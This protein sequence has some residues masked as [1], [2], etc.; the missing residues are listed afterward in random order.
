MT[1]PI[2]RNA[3]RRG[4]LAVFGLWLGA[5][6]PVGSA[7]A[8][9]APEPLVT[10]VLSLAELRNVVSE[11]GRSIRSFRAE[12]LVCAVNRDRS[13]L[14][15]QDS[16]AGLVLE[17]PALD[18]SI[19]PGDWVQVAGNECALTRCRFGLQ[20]GTAPVVNNDGHHPA[21]PKSGTVFLEAGQQ[22]I[23]VTWFNGRNASALKVEYEGPGIPRQL[24]PSAVL[25]RKTNQA[26]APTALGPGLD[27]AA[28][29]GNWT[30]SLPDFPSLAP[31][32]RGIATNFDLRYSARAE[33]AG[34]VFTGFIKIAR[35][36]IHAFYV[37][38]DDGGLLYAGHPEGSCQIVVLDHRGLPSP[39][40][41]EG[42]LAGRKDNSWT[43]VEGEVTFVGRDD[44]DAELGLTTKDGE[45]VQATIVH[46][47]SSLAT[48]WLQ[49]R[50][51][52]DGILEAVS[53]AGRQPTARLIIVPGASQVRRVESAEHNH[54]P[55]ISSGSVLTSIGRIRNL[56]RTDAA[57]GLPAKIRGVVIWNSYEACVLED[58]TGG[59][60]I[61]Y[62]A[63]EWTEEPAVGELWEI[64]GITDPGAFSPILNAQKATFLG[65][66]AMPVPIRPAGDQLLNGSLDAEY[67][68]LRGA[69]TGITEQELTLLTSEGTVR[70]SQKDDWPL[71]RLPAPVSP[72]QS[73]V[74]S[75]VRIRGCVMARVVSAQSDADVRLHLSPATIEIEDLVP[76]EPFALPPRKIAD[77]VG[78]D[79][80]ASVLQRTK[81]QGQIVFGC[82]GEY[83]LQD[84]DSGLRLLTKRPESLQPGDVVEAVGFPQLGGPSP[85]LKEAR[86]KTLRRQPLPAPVRLA[87]DDV[88]N[89][90]HDSTLVQVEAMLLRDL[91]RDQRMLELQA[92]RNHFIARWSAGQPSLASLKAGSRLLVTGVYFGG[93]G[94]SLDGFQLWLNSPLDIKV[95]QEPPWWTLARAITIMAM[96][97]TVLCLASVWIIE[98]RRKVEERTAQLKKQIEGRQLLEQQRV[99]EQ[100]R[101]RVA[102]DLHDELGAG[103]TEVGLLGDLVKNPALPA[104]EK[105]QYLGQ[106]TATARSLVASL[107]E[108]VWAVNPRYDSVASLASYYAL[109]AQRFLELA[110]MTCRLQIPADF[111][112]YPLDSKTRH[113]LFLA[114]KEALNNVVHHSGASEVRLKISVIEG[115][116]VI[117]VADNGR[118]FVSVPE[119][120]GTDGLRGMR[121]RMEHLGGNCDVQSRLEAG[122]E[123]QLRLRF[124]GTPS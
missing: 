104:L 115:E 30:C 74:D 119:Q 34:L 97:A 77:L 108:I 66:A 23:R 36:G 118:G 102:Q 86:I 117:S 15:L 60:Y 85:I 43:E 25:F 56:P 91:D 79:P 110:G 65:N 8:D 18:A 59:V 103:L 20:L 90:R 99:M 81:I 82:D 42:T 62:N 55:E 72:N 39:Q 3:K 124:H 89:S 11:H 106:L 93:N 96:L 1:R 41:F 122:T 10:N 29:T 50:C 112:E 54:P 24:I 105:Q 68:E 76:P 16:S 38:S 69:L 28:Y 53:D 101:T 78:F 14:A 84:G 64:E 88:F 33:N 22:P 113:G 73:L 47:S 67:V 19:Q 13:L 21:V 107:D 87:A 120:P 123:I 100:E 17:V 116:L 6:A 57:R 45:R 80:G 121:R 52:V 35:S 4:L 63:G 98:L 46:G 48:N 12:G 26:D 31:V 2:G 70:I 83:C 75:I 71:P 49:Q 27:Y 58:A 61:Q 109:F 40:P 51:R 92:G 5:L 111:P 9:V 94:G 7:A 32:A 44:E 37:E 95:L 114:F